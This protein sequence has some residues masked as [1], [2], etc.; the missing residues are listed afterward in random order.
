MLDKNVFV[1]N[2]GFHKIN[3]VIK[4]VIRMLKSQAQLQKITFT[5]FEKKEEVAAQ[6]D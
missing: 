3:Q 5:F 6:F 1:L 2:L 4:N